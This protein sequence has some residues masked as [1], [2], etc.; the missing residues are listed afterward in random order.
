MSLRIRYG[1]NGKLLKESTHI[2]RHTRHT[3]CFIGTYF[4]I[5]N[6]KKIYN[7]S[8]LSL[9]YPSLVVYS[10]IFINFGSEMTIEDLTTGTTMT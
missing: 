3:L 5:A 10:T 1:T 9:R 4:K 6:Q 7:F 8:G 2:T